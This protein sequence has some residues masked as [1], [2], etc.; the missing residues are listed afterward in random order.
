[1][2][3]D[4][5]CKNDVWTSYVKVVTSLAAL[6][7]LSYVEPVH[8][9]YEDFAGVDSVGFEVLPQQG[10]CRTPVRSRPRPEQR[11]QQD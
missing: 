3:W 5:T 9:F 7:S 10:Q 1:M 6:M 8:V 4:R 11:V 2:S